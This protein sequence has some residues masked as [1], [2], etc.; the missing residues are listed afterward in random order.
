[1]IADHRVA[2]LRRRLQVEQVPAFV[3]TDIPNIRYVTGFEGV[4]DDH[5]NAACLV[6]PEVTLVYTDSRYAEAAQTA[7]EG[8]PWNVRIPPESLY[9]DL[10]SDITEMGIDGLALESSAPYGRFRF[11][12]EKFTGRVKVVD[13][14]VEEIRRVK[15]SAE[16]E[17]IAAA[18]ELTD[19]AFDHILGMIEPGVSEHEIG[20]ELEMW[21]RRHGSVG[22][23]FD[24]IVASGPNSSRPHAS[25]TNRPLERGDFVTLDFGAKVDGYCADMTRTVCIGA[26]DER[27][28]EVYE[29]VRAANEAGIAAVRAGM[30]GASIDAA[31][32][33]LLGSRDLG[34]YFGHGLGHGVGIEVHELPSVS[35]RGRESVLAGAVVTIEPGVYIPGLWGVRIEDL[36]V[37]EEAGC[38]LLS[39][40]TKELIEL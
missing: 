3:V 33:D 34:Q 19:R 9:I 21:M 32:R 4:F 24:P 38:R 2:A 17:R 40:S 18:A 27:Q 20:L 28:R 14:W 1:M 13:Q 22:L 15:E 25:V 26:P 7:A 12:S 8:T 16:I 11:I 6:T 29:A 31:A 37:V 23:A 35:P 36:V 5:A 10:C 30:T 39:T